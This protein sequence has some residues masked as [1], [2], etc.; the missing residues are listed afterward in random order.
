MLADLES[1]GEGKIGRTGFNLRMRF[2]RFTI[3]PGSCPAQQ[4]TKNVSFRSRDE[5][6]HPKLS[7]SKFFRF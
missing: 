5:Y 7:Q 1:I 2:P 6:S 4:T 3:L